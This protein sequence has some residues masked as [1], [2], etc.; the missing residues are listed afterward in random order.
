MQ[1]ATILKAT[2]SQQ[3]HTLWVSWYIFRLSECGTLETISFGIDVKNEWQRLFLE[4]AV[5]SGCLH[6]TWL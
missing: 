4:T 1:F 2:A 6:F 3:L 5:G